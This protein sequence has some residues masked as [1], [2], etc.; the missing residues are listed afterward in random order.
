MVM[1]QGTWS[2]IILYFL[3]SNLMRSLKPWI[4]HCQEQSIHEGHL[5]RLICLEEQ[6]VCPMEYTENLR[7]ETLRLSALYLKTINN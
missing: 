7:T 5:V 1:Q 6:Y 4:Y 3:I 2:K